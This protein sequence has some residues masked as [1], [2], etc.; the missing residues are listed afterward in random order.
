MAMLLSYLKC[1]LSWRKC[2][3]G[4]IRDAFWKTT[5]WGWRRSSPTTS[6]SS[7]FPLSLVLLAIASYFPV[8]NL[9]DDMFRSSEV[10]AAPKRCR[11]STDQI[12]ED[13]RRQNGG[14][15]TLGLLTALCELL[16]GDDLGHRT[17]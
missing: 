5:A 1:P 4:S 17:R 15:L 8:A 2:S 12:Q 16:G 7:L 13:L 9:I 14:L 3:G 10:R 6:S 11:S